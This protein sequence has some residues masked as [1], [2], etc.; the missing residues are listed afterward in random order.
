MSHFGDPTFRYHEAMARIGGLAMLRLANAD[1]LPF[2][3]EDYAEEI[4]SYVRE[5]REIT[6][7]SLTPEISHL[8][9]KLKEFQDVGKQLNRI[10]S[11]LLAAE[12]PPDPQRTAAINNSLLQ[13]ERRFCSPEGIPHRPWYKHL[14]YACKYTYDPEVLPGVTEAVENKDWELAR[15]QIALLA[16]AVAKATRSLARATQP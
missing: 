14:V 2:N 6:P 4:A 8:L 5:I 9:E 13:V 10:I 11:V 15:D 16:R 7:G 1:I 3:Y 12:N